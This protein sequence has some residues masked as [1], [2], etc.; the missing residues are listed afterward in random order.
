MPKK[1]L[2]IGVGGTGKW[3]LTLLKER[4]EETYGFVPNDVVLLSIDIDDMREIDQ[5]AG[6]RLL[7]RASVEGNSEFHLVTP[8]QANRTMDSIFEEINSGS[9]KHLDWIELEK[10][11]RTLSNA[12]KS[13]RGGAQ[14]RRP[15]G[16]TAFFEDVANIQNRLQQALRQMYGEV[17]RD[18]QGV[19]LPEQSHRQVFII[20][21][22][23]GGTGSG[24]FIDTAN[25]VR[26]EMNKNPLW[27]T[28]ELSG[29]IIL[30]EAFNSY[31]GAGRMEDPTNLK[32][33]TFAA[34]RE[35]DR[36]MRVHTASLPYM[37]LL[38]S[39]N[40]NVESVSW[41]RD[42]LFDHMYLV[43]TGGNA[44][45]SHTNLTGDPT[46]SA[47]PFMADMV[48]CY[49]DQSLSGTINSKRN[50]VGMLTDR[51][52][53]NLYSSFNLT[54]YIFPMDDVI[55][56]FTYRFLR[57]LLNRYYRPLSG[58]N[59]TKIEAAAT[60][61][62]LTQFAQSRVANTNNPLLLQKIVAAT[63]RVNP[64]RVAMT[65]QG[66][67][68]LITISD[69][70]YAEDIKKV[71]GWL[72]YIRR[73]L[74]PSRTGDNLG[75]DFE[76]GYDR[77]T[78]Q[79]N[80]FLDQFFGKPSDPKDDQS[81]GG[82]KCDA[83]LAPYGDA[84]RERVAT[85][86][87]AALLEVLNSRN[88]QGRLAPGRLTSASTM[89]ETLR[90][91]LRD[92]KTL[93]NRRYNDSSIN[94]LI[95][96]AGE[97]VREATTEMYN[98]RE[99]RF[100]IPGFQPP[101]RKAQDVYIAAFIKRVEYGLLERVYQTVLSV[102]DEIGAVTNLPSGLCSLLEEARISLEAWQ[103]TI[104][105]LDK[106]LSSRA[107]SLR[108]ARNDKAQV[109]S[110]GVRI[111]LTNEPAEK[112]LYATLPVL[113]TIEQQVLALDNG[114]PGLQWAAKD[115]SRLFDLVLTTNCLPD[116]HLNCRY[117]GSRLIDLVLKTNW[118]KACNG[119]LDMA[120]EFFASIKQMLQP[121]RTQVALAD[122]LKQKFG[123]SN[124]LIDAV[125][126]ID[127]PFLRY[128]SSYNHDK[129]TMVLERYVS[130][131]TQH[132]TDEGANFIKQ[133][134][135]ALH[136][137]GFQVDSNAESEVACTVLLIARAVRLAAVNQ[138]NDCQESYQAKVAE[139][140]ESLHLFTAEQQATLY[141]KRITSLG[142][143]NDRLRILSPDVTIALGNR[144]KVRAFVLGCAYGLITEQTHVDPTTN[145]SSRE[146]FLEFGA[147]GTNEHIRIQLTSH[148]ILRTRDP[149]YE[150][151]TGE[152]K[153]ARRY[154]N[155]FQNFTLLLLKPFE[156]MT[157]LT[158]RLNDTLQNQK[159]KAAHFQ[160]PFN[161]SLQQINAEIRQR[162]FALGPTSA[163]VP[164]HTQRERENAQR[165]LRADAPLP[166][167]LEKRVMSF[168]QSEVQR[169]LDMA[170]V[171]R[172][173]IADELSVFRDLAHII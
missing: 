155:A 141:E 79:S 6:T 126:E 98:T 152:E 62:T 101:A 87:A 63:R 50:N 49:V 115:S 22:L 45:R 48:M 89:I 52:E 78:R 99:R 84:L 142:D 25:L 15:I 61:Y 165:C 136:Q 139:G 27:A 132:A 168:R 105:N 69:G 150:I 10:L 4:L 77:L 76:D 30:P 104:D 28:I 173:V 67:Y 35:I 124:R 95:R 2:A 86:I 156:D 24:M 163:E 17:Q 75:E 121:M 36:F 140:K 100:A 146:I 159:A 169:I 113:K 137:Q 9:S 107:R 46:R 119:Y 161:E 157:G 21:S 97:Q 145:I 16:R 83:I 162:Q 114:T 118:S 37:V 59:Q 73:N 131:N 166:T 96:S 26:R 65:W 117:E 88:S 58:D 110:S 164:D 38:G 57:D 70:A 44:S 32:P 51:L 42:Q 54:S 111:Y 71:E 148:E 43:D 41:A 151:V 144:D 40:A 90:E 128:N 167:F 116:K 158:D 80:A 23:A 85:V 18:D 122:L 53:G 171:M 120:N 11:N 102:L 160:L 147:V 149:T 7:N 29:M 143:R 108:D 130:F 72:E 60:E 91:L 5:F 135:N 31:I 19:A 3:V 74:T 47:F 172:L 93:L 12:Q 112:Q 154:L 1:L 134:E 56:S 103:Q 106:E 14:Q 82:G 66:L 109:E 55:E 138:F 170:T 20:G 68:G 127:Q 123:H 8:S 129:R 153:R 133:T 34:L 13:I 125:I 92:F 81:R 33:N 64:E 39:L 94:Q